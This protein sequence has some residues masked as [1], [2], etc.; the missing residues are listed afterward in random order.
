[1]E[2]S[3][4]SCRRSSP[5]PPLI[6]EETDGTDQANIASV[7]YNRLG[8]GNKQGTYGLRRSTPLCSMLPDHTGPITSADMQTDSPYNLYQNAACPHAH[9]QPGPG[10]HR[11]GAEPQ[12]HGLLLLRPGHRR[13]APLLHHAGGTQRVRQQQLL[14]RLSGTSRAAGPGGGHERLKMAVLSARMRYLAGTSYGMRAFAGNFSDEELP[15]AVALPTATASGSTAPSI[16]CPGTTRRPAAG[17]WNGWRTPGGRLIVADLGPLPWRGSTPRCERH[18]S[19]Q[20][21]ICNYET[22]RA[23]HDLGPTG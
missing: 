4:Y 12:Q 19:T 10:L 15:Q 1:M 23:W 16:P 9:L 6:E 5:S 17:T 7:I 13:Q 3:S 2:E 18:I 21:S 14:W 11:R 20:A 8:S 22:A